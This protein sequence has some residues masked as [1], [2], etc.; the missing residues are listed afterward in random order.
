[1]AL[2]LFSKI[3]PW[4]F[5]KPIIFMVASD[6]PFSEMRRIHAKEV[7]KVLNSNAKLRAEWRR[8]QAQAVLAADK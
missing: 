1:M 5:A 2:G 7:E 3:L 4:F 8:A 6:L